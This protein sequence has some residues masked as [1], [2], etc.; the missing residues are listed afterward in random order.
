[1]LIDNLFCVLFFK[2][3][4]MMIVE[5]GIV[6]NKGRI[7]LFENKSKYFYLFIKFFEIVMLFI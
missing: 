2:F 5:F 3:D 4:I 1:M 6:F 7:I